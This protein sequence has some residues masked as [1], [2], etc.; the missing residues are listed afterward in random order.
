MTI[1]RGI[2]VAKKLVEVRYFFPKSLAV[3]MRDFFLKVGV[4]SERFCL[5]ISASWEFYRQ[6]L[7]NAFALMIVKVTRQIYKFFES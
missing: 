2:I 6:I 3:G 1:E 7:T 5:I 4:L